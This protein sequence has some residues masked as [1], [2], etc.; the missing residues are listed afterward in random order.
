MAEF[1]YNNVPFTLIGLP[2]FFANYGYYP[3]VYNPP[4]ELCA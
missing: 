2:P 3:L 1:V 4:A